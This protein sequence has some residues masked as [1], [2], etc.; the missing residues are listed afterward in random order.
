MFPLQSLSSLWQH[1]STD[2]LHFQA[3][4]IIHHS[5]FFSATPYEAH[6]QGW[7]VLSSF[8][9][10]AAL[11]DSDP[12]LGKMELINVLV[13]K[14]VFQCVISRDVS[15]KNPS[16]GLDVQ[17]VGLDMSEMVYPSCHTPRDGRGQCLGQI[18]QKWVVFLPLRQFLCDPVVHPWHPQVPWQ[19]LSPYF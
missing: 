12:A 13:L 15:W 19:D 14:F 6:P 11:V 3:R 7:S 2:K 10:L 17:G 18:L 4:G 8:H 1:R 9:S 5:L 16:L